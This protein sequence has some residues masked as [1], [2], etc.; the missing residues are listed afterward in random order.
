MPREA[1]ILSISLKIASVGKDWAYRLCRGR[2]VQ[3]QLVRAR[4]PSGRWWLAFGLVQWDL[5]RMLTSFGPWSFVGGVGLSVDAAAPL[6]VLM[7]LLSSVPWVVHSSVLWDC[8]SGD[9]V[10][11]LDRIVPEAF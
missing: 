10:P 6:W 11:G 9:S 7:A 2:E 8:H 3:Q 4:R 5:G 1:L